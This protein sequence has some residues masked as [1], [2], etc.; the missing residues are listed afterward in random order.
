MA[1]QNV[2]VSVTDQGSANPRAAW[3][4]N[5]TSWNNGG[6]TPT[7]ANGT[8]TGWQAIAFSGLL[9]MF[10]A[11][12]NNGIQNNNND[13]M[14]STDGGQTWTGHA[15]AA[16]KS[17]RDGCWSSDLGL[18]CFVGDAGAIITS[19]DGTTWTARTPPA[20]LSTH[21]FRSVCWAHS[22]GLFIAVSHT[23][24]GGIMTS[25]DGVTWTQRTNPSTFTGLN[26]VAWSSSGVG[27]AVGFSSGHVLTTTD[28]INWTD[29]DCSAAL[30]SYEYVGGACADES[31]LNNGASFAVTPPAA[32][33]FCIVGGNLG[34]VA[35]SNDGVTWTRHDNTGGSGTTMRS[36]AY[37]NNTGNWVVADG[38]GKIVTS[39]DGT[40]WTAQT[41]PTAIVEYLAAGYSV[42]PP[43]VFGA[44]MG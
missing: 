30:S 10:V 1:N 13:Y 36:A 22:I 9:G 43:S 38:S 31:T 12:Q 15:L 41:A 4:A 26:V 39:P 24:P 20:G 29:N 40:T 6:N 18:F 25:P 7:F 27:I 34:Q 44:Q 19:P 28:G 2:I 17:W 35:V 32:K 14:V 42:V 8:G 11:M 16:S 5:D 21:N 37:D 33:R 23:S 3:S